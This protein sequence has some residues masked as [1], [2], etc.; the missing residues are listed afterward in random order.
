MNVLAIIIGDLDWVFSVPNLNQ[1]K[2]I[3]TYHK[4]IK[5]SWLQLQK[6]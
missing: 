2:W 3:S 6:N 5:L 4:L 1:H